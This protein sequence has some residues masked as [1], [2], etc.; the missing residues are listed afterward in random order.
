VAINN[1]V[2]V[3]VVG[4]ANKSILL[5][6]QA[7]EGAVFGKDL[8]FGDG[9]T[10]VTLQN[11]A[12]ALGVTSQTVTQVVQPIVLWDQITAIPP[13][14]LQVATLST[15]GIVRRL[16]NGAWITQPA[17]DFIGRPGRPG[18]QGRHGPPGVPGSNGPRGTIGT[19]IP[20]RKGGRGRQGFPGLP[21]PRGATG[22]QGPAGSA[23]SAS[24][25]PGRR[26]LRGK[27]GFPGPP[28]S[29]GL[30]GPI[31]PAGTASSTSGFPGYR[32]KPVP[33][34]RI[35][36]PDNAAPMVWSG[37]A[38]FTGG[39]N[40]PTDMRRSGVTPG[41][42][43]SLPMVT[44][45]NA[46]QATDAR[47]WRQYVTGTSFIF[48]CVKDDNS[49]ADSA[50]T[51]VR[52]GAALTAVSI[53]S[54]TSLATVI[55]LNGPT[56][57][58]SQ[59]NTT[60]LQ[61]GHRDGDYCARFSGSATAGSS[62]GLRVAAG[63]NASDQTLAFGNQASTVNFFTIAGDGTIVLGASTGT[64]NTYNVASG[65]THA[66]Q[67]NSAAVIAINAAPTTGATNPSGFTNNKPGSSGGGPTEW[68]GVLNA[69]GQQRWI[70]LYPN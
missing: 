62:F 48:D 4:A 24:S 15:A 7:T 38:Q 56:V 2:K 49:G 58:A 57:I 61:V 46:A 25:F 9:K 64:G 65:K 3:P 13:N 28:G 44:F 41:A 60:P 17:S 70:P 32:Q 37:R 26:G 20:G 68:L 54:G 40:V 59:N 19:G 36:P 14:V 10:V 27:Q 31:G 47:A 45:I 43:G 42:A 67:I 29:Q 55:T 18:R 22:P 16:P 23:S 35:V 50:L 5:N 66:F 8:F 34:Q 39:A 11:L 6:P 51:F 63:T 69:S 1:K 52:T 33:K 30:Q 53:G 21:G 12:Q